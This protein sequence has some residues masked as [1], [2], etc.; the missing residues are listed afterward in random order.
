VAAEKDIDI[1][2]D[3]LK[4]ET[5]FEAAFR[6]GEAMAR[7]WLAGKG[8]LPDL[9]RIVRDM[10]QALG[11][12]EAGFLSAIE[13]SVRGRRGAGAPDPAR[14]QAALSPPAESPS[15]ET[16]VEPTIDLDEISRRSRERER[17][18]RMEQWKRDNEEAW[19]SQAYSIDPRR[20]W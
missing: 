18:A 16:P 17:K 3:Q 4:P 13:A 9:V 6:E 15:P 1:M 8:P 19:A 11:G 14:A 10:P 5:D 20:W 12:L 7:E 2:V